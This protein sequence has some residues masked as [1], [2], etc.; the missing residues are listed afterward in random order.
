MS[1]FQELGRHAAEVGV[2]L[3]LEMYEDTFLGTADSAVRLIEEIGLP[4]VGLNPD[5]ANLVRLHRPVE[6][7]QELVEKTLPVHELLARQEL[8]ARRGPGARRLLLR[9]RPDAV[10]PDR[11]PV[12]VPHGARERA[13]R[14]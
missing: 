1:R 8:L 7:W 6:P 3:S 10:R 4:E 13:S 11:L 12:R 9:A 2:L 5:I 14:A